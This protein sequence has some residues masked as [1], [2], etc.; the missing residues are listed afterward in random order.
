MEL[1]HK[2]ERQVQKGTKKKK[3]TSNDGNHRRISINI[4]QKPL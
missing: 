1:Q 4:G 2:A 3:V